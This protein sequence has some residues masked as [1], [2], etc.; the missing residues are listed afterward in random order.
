VRD[1]LCDVFTRPDAPTAVDLGMRRMYSHFFEIDNHI[2]RAIAQ[3][4]S[5]AF[6][7]ELLLAIAVRSLDG[8]L[9][10]TADPAKSKA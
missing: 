5:A 7:E 2:D 1:W 6:E 9:A 4:S 3:A 10:K 8:L